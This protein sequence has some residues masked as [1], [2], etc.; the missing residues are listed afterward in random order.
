[1]L[2]K[3]V[4]ISITAL[5]VLLDQCIK[6]FIH[7]FFRNSEINIIGEYIQFKPYLNIEYS[8]INSLLHLGIGRY[9]HIL[10]LILVILAVGICFKFIR[11]MKKG[12][13]LVDILFIV[14]I[15]GALCSLIDKVFWGGSL[16]YIALKGLFIFDLKD[17]YITIFEMLLAGMLVFNYKGLRRMDDKKLYRNFKSFVKNETGAFGR[18]RQLK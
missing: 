12:D 4:C 13:K 17:V 11:A 15:S 9:I 3:P 8:W 7:F 5:L 16:D 2:K 10:V 6:L 14:I 18:S 1:M